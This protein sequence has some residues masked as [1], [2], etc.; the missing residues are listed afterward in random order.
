MKKAAA[1]ALLLAL[2]AAASAAA[3]YGA[4]FYD[5]S[6]YLA[7]RVAVN[8]IFVQSNGSIDARTETNGWTT[9]KKNSVVSEVQNAMNWWVVRN[10][11]AGLSFYYSNTTVPTGYEPIGR[12]STDEELWVKQVMGSLGYGEADAYDRVFHYNADKRDALG[13]DWSYTIFVV[14]SEQDSDGEFADNFF[15]YAYIGGPFVVMTY[16]NDG[17]GI[18]NMESVAA[19]EMGHIFY[20]LDEY[21]DSGCARTETSGYLNGA[22]SN[23]ENGGAA[24]SCIMRGDVGPYYTPAICTHTAKALGWSDDLPGPGNG[25]LDI[26][27]LPPTTALRPYAPDPTTNL[28]LSFTGAAHSTAAY[29]NANTYAFWGSPRAGNDISINR[30]AAVEYRLNSGAWL[31][32]AA[33]DGTFDSNAENFSFTV[34]TASGGQTVLARALDTNN[35]YDPTPASD[36]LTINTGNPTDIPYVQDSLGDDIDYSASKSRVAANWG[37]SAHGSGINRYMYA[38]GTAPGGTNT[39]NWTTAGVSTWVVHNIGLAE[40]NTYYFSVRAHANSGEVSGVSTSDGFRVDSTSPTAHVIV[41]SALPARTGA[42][43]AKLVVTE[44][45]PMGATPQLSF[46]TSGGL[47]VP[48]TM[49]FLTGSTWTASG[50]VESFHSTG[51]ASF[52]FSGADMAGNTGA[53]ITSG[54]SFALNYALAGGS[55]GTVTN[56]DGFSAYL[57]QGSYAGT[58][59]VS[60]STVPAATLAAADPGDS[61]KVDSIDLARG[62]TARDAAGNP[63]TSFSPALTLTLAYPDADSDGRVDSDLTKENTLWVYYLDPGLNKWVPL[64]GVVR[65]AAANSLTVPVDHFSV[66]SIRSANSSASGIGSLKA[67]PN[68]CDLRVT[69]A[70]TIEG[71]PVDAVGTRVYIYNTAGELVRTLSAGDGVNGLNVVSWDGT[72]DKGAKA[73]S[74]LYLYLVKTKNYGKVTGKVY[75]IW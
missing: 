75:I 69:P 19:H 34:S 22:N 73:A 2:P 65:D 24:V 45:N 49:S 15:A 11:A 66:Y 35:S 1:L 72:Q 47:V 51:T 21:A 28:T 55:S 37:S 62:F 29:A 53:T 58:L 70:L 26:L 32:A 38:V 36:T 20:A 40:G 9:A 16:D 4:G 6:E 10:S 30:V 5:T 31:Q 54:G 13:A 33:S 41:T 27:D 23:C 3:P 12:P 48:L 61:K 67:W 71:L 8:I 18:S 46:R 74:G 43:S 68:P 44:A 64:P 50:S 57:P 56:S 60:I 52:L 59:F 42:F 25:K 14:D 7:G 39:V 17:Y 63:V